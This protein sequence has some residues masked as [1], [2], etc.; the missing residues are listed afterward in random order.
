MV[1]GTA[2]DDERPLGVAGQPVGQPGQLH[3]GVDGFRPGVAE[4]HAGVGD[5]AEVRHPRGQFVGR[6]VRERIEARVGG[7]RAQLRG[8]R[9]GDL[10]AS[11]AD[12]AV[13]EAGHR[14]HVLVP[15]GVP[16]Q[17]A[18]AAD[19]RHERLAGGLGERVQEPGERGGHAGTVGRRSR[20]SKVEQW[21]E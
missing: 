17:R 16:H 20:V 6:P 18:L 1:A 8:H 5:R 3:A 12:G 14:V 7:E 15:V 10:D 2:A 21:P 19:D 13:P 11:V 4:E 9:I